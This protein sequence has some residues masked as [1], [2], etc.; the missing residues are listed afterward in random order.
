MCVL[1][2]S[3]V[4]WTQDLEKFANE[5]GMVG[6]KKYLA[7]LEQELKDTVDL[8]RQKLTLL[9]TITLGALIVIDVHAKNVIQ[10]LVDENI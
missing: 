9:Q 4:H 3:Q 2:G 8:V 5:E 1:N 10:K 6:I 7:M